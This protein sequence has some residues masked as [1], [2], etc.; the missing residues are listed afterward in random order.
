MDFC[1][2]SNFVSFYKRFNLNIFF[3]FLKIYNYFKIHPIIFHST[4]IYKIREDIIQVSLAESRGL[5]DKPDL[6]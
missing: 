5:I 2:V 3:C 4:F 6:I 1:S